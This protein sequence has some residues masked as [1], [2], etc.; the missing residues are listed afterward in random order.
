[1]TKLLLLEWNSIPIIETGRNR[2]NNLMEVIKELNCC[3]Y[4]WFYVKSL[5]HNS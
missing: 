5:G 3:S 1:M 4:F 2:I